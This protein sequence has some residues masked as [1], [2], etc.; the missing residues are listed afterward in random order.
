[1]PEIKKKYYIIGNPVEH[2]LSP[3]LHSYIYK[4]FNLSCSYHKIRIKKAELKDF[5]ITC[6]LKNISGFN[7]TI[8][9]KETIIP[10]LDKVEDE[11]KLFGAVNTVKNEKGKLYGYNTDIIGCRYAL[12]RS[13]WQQSGKVVILGAGG[14]ARSALAA[15]SSFTP[16]SVSLFNRTPEKARLLKDQFSDHLN[17]DII[18]ENVKFHNM[19]N[20]LSNTTLLINTTPVGMWPETQ[21]SPISDSKIIPENITIFDMVPNPVYTT[22]LKDAEKRGAEIISGL[23]ML[24]SQAVAAQEIWLERKIPL[25]TFNKLWTHI[26]EMSGQYHE[27][28]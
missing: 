19:E 24:I 2:S 27:H 3:T 28:D 22:L 8:P 7:V 14:A 1:M 11:A 17:F 20:L 10:L 25:E 23:S 15:L 16:S 12:K 4:I 26:I 21:N 5:I 13:S 9:H 18:A 6:R